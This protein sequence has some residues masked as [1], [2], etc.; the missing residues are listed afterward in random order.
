MKTTRAKK[1][2]K[3]RFGSANHLLITTLVGLDGIESGVIT[4]KPEGFQ[5]YWNPKSPKNSSK[6][7]RCFVLES[8]LGW[9]V[10]SLEMYLTEINR[11]PKILDSERFTYLFSKADRS[12]Y[13]KATFIADEIKVDPILIALVEVLITW[14]NYTFHYDIDNEIRP[15]SLAVLQN[16]KDEV[17]TRFSGLDID[18]MKS[19]WEKKEDFTF[20][21]TSSLINATQLFVDAIDQYAIETMDIERYYFETIYFQLKNNINS[22]EKYKN[23]PQVQKVKYIK[24]L[25]QNEANSEK[26]DDSMLEKLVVKVNSDKILKLTGETKK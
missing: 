13:D 8:F 23:L 17:K 21:E 19:V 12:V 24:T 2:F 3:K 26:I 20:K 22:Y 7:A 18:V 16:K 6:W 25:L 10:E 11:K 9:A 5:T 1:E 14:R 15:Q 4:Q